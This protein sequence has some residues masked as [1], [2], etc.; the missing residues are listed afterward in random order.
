METHV[1]VVAWLHIILGA[2]GVL[3]AVCAFVSIAG[4]GLISGEQEAIIATSITAIAIAFFVV[5]VSVPGII[6]GIGLLK[7]KSWGR[8]LTI[9]VAVLELPGFPIGTALGIY[10]LW[11]LFQNET[12]Q[13][14]AAGS[15]Q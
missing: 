11:V 9:I 8:I 13:L 15:S 6:A 4:G 14:F 12:A 7:W 3:G 2:L 10:A 1:K 5:M